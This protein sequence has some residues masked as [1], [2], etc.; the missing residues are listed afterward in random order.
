MGW[1]LTAAIAAAATF[2]L[3]R[4]WGLAVAISAAVL[5]LMAGIP[6]VATVLGWQQ[7]QHR[8]EHHHAR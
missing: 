3:A 4:H 1:L 5:G 7:R 2:L 8:Q 6:V